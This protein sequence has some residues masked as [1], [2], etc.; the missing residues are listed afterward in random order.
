MKSSE[1]VWRL[2]HDQVVPRDAVACPLDQAFGR[3]LRVDV[4]ARED[5]PAFDRSAVDGF[6]VMSGDASESFRIVGEI[7]AG[8]WKP[9]KLSGGEALRIA[10]G[11][12]NGEVYTNSDGNDPNDTNAAGYTFVASMHVLP[13]TEAFGDAWMNQYSTDQQH[14]GAMASGANEGDC[15]NRLMN[16]KLSTLES[17]PRLRDDAVGTLCQHWYSRD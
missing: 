17:Y 13:I 3:V 8:D 4:K 14:V 15:N 1:E 7:R 12:A 2:L 10:T 9:A 5:Q 11:G 6:A 16:M